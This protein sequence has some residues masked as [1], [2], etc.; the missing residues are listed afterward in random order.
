MDRSEFI[1]AI[2]FGTTYTGVAYFHKSGDLG[3]D[4]EEIAEKIRVI[5]SWPNNGQDEKVRTILSYQNGRPIWG[6]NVLPYHEPQITRF[7]LGLEDSVARFYVASASTPQPPSRFLIFRRPRLHDDKEA[8]DYTADYLTCLY[9]YLHD[10]FFRKQFGTLALAAQRFT[11]I[12][13]VPAIWSD[14]AKDLTRQ[15]AIRAGIPRESLS[16]VT[17]PEAAALFCGTLSQVE[18][19]QGDRFLICDA[20]GGTVD[21]ISYQVVESTPKFSVE[22]C[23]PG[24]GGAWGAIR[25][26][27]QFQILLKRKLGK[28]ADNLLTKKKLEESMAHFGPYLKCRF[29]PYDRNREPECLIPFTGTP[30]IPE[31]GIEKE[32]LKF[33]AYVP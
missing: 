14:K 33:H 8:I 27:E 26:D 11:Y 7:K 1:V 30:D 25:L 28:Y 2:D 3:N 21:L 15:A 9:D 31:I 5:K 23:C 19:Q 16:L 18:L 24:T 29:N 22:E 20:G 13:T 17:E 10:V 6:G 12:I 32:Y 4:V